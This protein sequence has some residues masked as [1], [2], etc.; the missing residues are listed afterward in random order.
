MRILLE[1][2]KRECQ[3]WSAM[4]IFYILYTVAILGMGFYVWFF[5]GQSLNNTSII[6]AIFQ[7]LFWISAV[8]IP[9]LATS[10]ILDER[11][12][13][14][15]ET[16][17]TKPLSIT[18]FV[19]GKLVAVNGIILSFFI[20]SLC[21]FFS[22]DKLSTIPTY[23][24]LTMYVFLFLIG[25]LYALISMAV[26]SFFTVYW[27]SYLVSYSIIFALHLCLTLLGDISTGEVQTLLHYWGLQS[28]FE[29]FLKGGFAVSSISYLISLILLTFFLIIYKLSKDN[30]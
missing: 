11:R 3:K 26:T 27:K 10:T 8:F 1:I 21:Y 14:T 5:K 18:Q 29:Y 12:L 24:L 15:L 23:Y 4:P 22:I 13:N 6:N 30:E 2:T 28:Q 20:F 17:L 19:L 7:A 9:I 25:T 16:L